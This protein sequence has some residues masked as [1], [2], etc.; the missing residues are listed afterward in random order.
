[1]KYLIFLTTLCVCVFFMSCTKTEYVSGPEEPETPQNPNA[2]QNPNPSTTTP[3]P[4]NAAV[5][6]A[7]LSQFLR[8]DSLY[9]LKAN[10]F[11]ARKGQYKV[12]SSLT[13]ERIQ[14]LWG[15]YESPSPNPILL[16]LGIYIDPE[17][18]NIHYVDIA[19]RFPQPTRTSTLPELDESGNQIGTVS[20]GKTFGIFIGKNLGPAAGG[21]AYYTPGKGAGFILL[22]SRASTVV[23]AHEL[24]HTLGVEHTDDPRSCERDSRQGYLMHSITYP[25][26]N[27][28]QTVK[29]CENL[30]ATDR[31]TTIKTFGTEVQ[32]IKN[33]VFNHS[34][35]DKV[36]ISKLGSSSLKEVLAGWALIEKNNKSYYGAVVSIPLENRNS[37]RR[38]AQPFIC[39]YPNHLAY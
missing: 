22:D 11:I 21:L 2:P 28:K 1:M 39:T 8:N 35:Y 3:P 25:G 32:H 16:Q 15:G 34:I 17:K 6:P 12:H 20:T 5:V 24:A 18:L 7:S 10:I 38:Y 30:I 14:S 29:E 33:T 36:H 13:K 9:I 37:A 31:T 4:T 23:I 27:Y 19:Q 26:T